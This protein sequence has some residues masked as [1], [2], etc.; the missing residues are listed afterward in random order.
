MSRYSSPFR[1]L[2]LQVSRKRLTQ[3]AVM[4]T[5]AFARFEQPL[6]FLRLHSTVSVRTPKSLGTHHL[7][8]QQSS[9][10]EVI[11]TP[12][13]VSVTVISTTTAPAKR[14]ATQTGYYG[15][16]PTYASACT[17]ADEYSSACFC[18]GVTPST[19]TLAAAASHLSPSIKVCH[20]L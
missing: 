17:D 6:Y 20:S 12:P 9:F 16:I 8:L 18:I 19:T 7:T 5:T 14:D 10:L 4:Q 3:A 13:P 1:V 11:V 15:P 2:L